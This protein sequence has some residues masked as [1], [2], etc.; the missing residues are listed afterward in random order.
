MHFL[1][2]EDPTSLSL[3]TG[4]LKKWIIAIRPATLFAS[5]SPV[6]LGSSIAYSEHLFH[7][8]SFLAALLGAIFIQI[9]TNLAND[10][11]DYIYGIDS[12]DRIGP[13][14]VTQ[15]GIIEPSFVKK[16]FILAFSLAILCGIYLIA[17]AG[18]PILIIGLL[19]ILFGICYSAGP[20][21]IS[22]LGL[23]D[24]AVIIFF[25]PV[26]V[27]GTYYVQALSIKKNVILLGLGP[28]FISNAILTVNNLRDLE[29]DKKAGKKSLAVRFGKRFA[30]AEYLLSLFIAFIIP[31]FF[32]SK[33][34]YMHLLACISFLIP[35]DYIKVLW[36]KPNPLYNV[37]LKRTSLSVFLYCLLFSIGWISD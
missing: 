26:A 7:L 31:F 10:Y 17:R 12:E 2:K 1:R 21:P 18:I 35:L 3:E 6:I 34:H 32:L 15:K 5:V 37:L 36:Q 24:L 30:Q 16:G 25:G 23:A 13:I 19:S 11:Y 9:G 29:A 22:H 28:G 4:T 27:A 20:F 14:R 8:P 33:R